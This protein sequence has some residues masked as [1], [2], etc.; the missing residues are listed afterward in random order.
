MRSDGWLRENQLQ[1]VTSSGL[2]PARSACGLSPEEPARLVAAWG[3]CRP[4]RP[5]EL[6]MQV[7]VL[8]L[9]YLDFLR[10]GADRGVSRLAV[11]AMDLVDPVVEKDA[12]RDAIRDAWSKSEF[13]V[14]RHTALL[15]RTRA[16]HHQAEQELRRC[17][18]DFDE[19]QRVHEEAFQD[20]IEPGRLLVA[21]IEHE[22]ESRMTE[23]QRRIYRLG[24][25]LEQ[26]TH[27]EEVH[28]EVF[29]RLIP[30]EDGEESEPTRYFAAGN[31]ENNVHTLTRHQLLELKTRMG[32]RHGLQHQADPCY[33]A[34]RSSGL[35]VSSCV[36]WRGRREW[37]R[38]LPRFGRNFTHA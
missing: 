34:D 10:F 12:L 29:M 35:S 9:E 6:G 4:G 13:A 36:L 7:A 5:G 30:A 33:L 26:V 3:R 11:L 27:R 20:L 31:P 17:R 8:K 18:S 21:G 23:W 37:V 14:D 2:D 19:F 32:A 15:E 16:L 22:L 25:V 24:R 1:G 38:T 28:N